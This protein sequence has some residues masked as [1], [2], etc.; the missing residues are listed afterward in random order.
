[1][2]RRLPLLICL[3]AFYA[4]L[5]TSVSGAEV[6]ADV[7]ARINDALP[8]KV[9]VEPQVARHVLLYSRTGGFRHASIE[10]GAK[11][12]QMLGE[13]TRAFTTVHSED[14]SMFDQENLDQFD[15]IVMLN[16]TG[17][18][19]AT[20]KPEEMTDEEKATHEKRRGNLLEFVES[21]K[22]VLGTHSSTDAFYNWKEYGDMMGGWFTGHPW[23]TD[24]PIKVDSPDHPLTAMFDANA[25]FNIKDEIYQFAPRNAEGVYGGYQPYDRSKLRVLLSLDQEKFDVSLGARNDADYAISWIREFGK[26]RIFYSVLGHNEFIFYTPTV[27]QHYLAGMQYVLGDLQ[28]DATPSGRLAGELQTAKSIE[29]FNKE[30]LKGWRLKHASGSHW[31]V[32]RAT[33]DSEDPGKFTVEDKPGELVNAQGGGVDIFTD[34][35]FGDCRLQIELMVPKGSNSGIY[36]HGNYEVQVFDSWG[37]QE[38]GPADIGGIYGAAAP[39]ENAAKEPGQWQQFII[40][41]KAPRFEGDK[42]VAN[43]M[44]ERVILNG[45]TIHE[46]VEVSGPT[47]G[48]LGLGE[49]ATGPLMFQGDHGAVSYRNIQ[50]FVPQ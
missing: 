35:R 25:G 17:D 31:V 42:K 49:A 43:A 14:P 40:D 19:L 48:N 11:S 15:A 9:V 13:K 26:G 45:K 34:E 23:H 7:I 39:K 3:T 38:A 20:K 8:D 18:F 36:L 12:F 1:M 16:V 33:L 50:L 41:F 4:F 5:A 46:N 27:M 29:P 2:V 30:N 10:T 28:A 24:V 32:G 37:K 6:R 47:G 21:G 44:F 22:G